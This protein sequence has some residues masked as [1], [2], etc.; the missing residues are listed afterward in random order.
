MQGGNILSEIVA[1]S[2]IIARVLQEEGIDAVFGV[3]GG[4]LFNVLHAFGERGIKVYHMRSEYSAGFAADAYARCL[5]RPAVTFSGGSPGITNMVSPIAHAQKAFT[6]LVGLVAQHAQTL[7]KMNASQEFDAVSMFKDMTKWSYLCTEWSTIAYWLRKAFRD[8]MAYPQGPVVISFPANVILARDDESKQLRDEVPLIKRA[9]PGRSQGDPAQI[10]EAVN[11]LQ[12]AQRPLVIAGDSIYWDDASEE[13]KQFVELFQCP[14]HTRR[15]AR[16]AVPEDHPLAFTGGS[17]QPLLDRADVIL[18]M[19]LQASQ[20]EEWFEPPIWSHNPR[21]IQ[22]HETPGAFFVTPPTEIAIVGSAK[23][24]LRQMIDCA[25][26]QNKKPV[27][28]TDW[29]TFTQE[30][31]TKFKERTRTKAERLRSQKPVHPSILAQEIVDFLDP[32][33][34]IVLDSFTASQSIVDRIYAQF[35]G[36]ILDTA[37]HQSVGNG[38]GM[39]LGAQLA[40]P[41]KQVIVVIGDGG[42]GI[43]GADIE[44]LR[45]WNLPVVTVILNND[46]WG[47]M[48]IAQKL[49]WSKSDP[50]DMMPGIRY[51]KM[52][53]QFG[54]HVEYVEDP[55]DLRGA[56]ERS[57][58][59]GIASVINVVGDTDIPHPIVRMFNLW[60]TWSHGNLE[61]LPEEAKVIL[62]KM[63]PRVVRRVHQRLRSMGL[64]VPLE[65]L[66]EITGHSLEEVLRAE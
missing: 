34:T 61:D 6:P 58:H 19:G 10:R 25:Q 23:L 42:I 17:R 2:R 45:K 26:N 53:E 18:L 38:I 66:V 12:N 57:F 27:D 3:L 37:L 49:F 13:L 22:V 50:W 48:S 51:D 14:V 31:G 52:Y 63:H 44:S 4:Q 64:F 11:M 54:C 33:A 8:A 29:I 39:A 5:R 9:H 56:L 47:G 24:V 15:S 43:A 41:G 1:G 40:R 28:K 20:L 65:E 16:G 35:P 21:Y 30:T 60:C 55:N 32:D 36:Q 7:D 62:K 59:S 46:S